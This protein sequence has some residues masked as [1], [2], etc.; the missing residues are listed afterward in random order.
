MSFEPIGSIF[1]RVIAKAKDDMELHKE[2]AD[3]IA[4]RIGS[5]DH[6][7]LDGKLYEAEATAAQKK[8]RTAEALENIKTL[9]ETTHDY[10][11]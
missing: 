4:D 2:R 1:E 8:A 3:L 11:K 9:I 5:E 6:H 7:R 10:W